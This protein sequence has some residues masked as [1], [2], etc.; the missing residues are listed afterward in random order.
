MLMSESLSAGRKESEIPRAQ[1][2]LIRCKLCQKKGVYKI[3][4]TMTNHCQLDAYRNSPGTKVI[5][6]PV[7][8]GKSNL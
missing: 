5:M 4:K 8:M 3:T 1:G 2:T 7:S 6:S